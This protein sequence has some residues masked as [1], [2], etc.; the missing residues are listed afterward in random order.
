MDGTETP[1][2][3]SLAT[4]QRYA[5]C[6]CAKETLQALETLERPSPRTIGPFIAGSANGQSHFLGAS[7]SG[8]ELK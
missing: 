3:R 2:A 1:E 8:Q 5:P 6:E 4:I 7:L